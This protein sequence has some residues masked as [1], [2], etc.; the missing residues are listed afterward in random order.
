M[1]VCYNTKVGGRGGCGIGIGMMEGNGMK[2]RRCM[3]VYVSD[4]GWIG[5]DWRDCMFV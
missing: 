3:M 2:G 4:D 5:L 1:G